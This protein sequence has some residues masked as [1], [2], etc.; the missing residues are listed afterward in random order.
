MIPV[1]FIRFVLELIP[2]FTLVLIFDNTRP[3]TRNWVWFPVL[4][5]LIDFPVHLSIFVILHLS[6]M[7]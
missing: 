1:Y 7:I 4:L 5:H 3:N 6:W 2:S